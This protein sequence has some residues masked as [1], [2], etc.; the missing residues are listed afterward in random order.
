MAIWDGFEIGR[1]RYRLRLAGEVRFHF[2][3]EGVL[4][5]VLS[6]ALGRHELPAG[7]MAA[8]PES[9]RV[10]YGAGDPYVFGVTLAGEAAGLLDELTG[11]L[12]RLGEAPPE[13]RPAP[14]LGGNFRLET[15]EELGPPDLAGELAALDGADAV[16]LQLLSPFRLE[17]PDDA[18]RRGAGFLDAGCFPPEH[19]LD[20]LWSRLFHLV[21]GRW[22][23]AADRAADRPPLP[24]EL[25]AD[26]AG[27]VWL[28]VPV[29]GKKERK[30]PY[31]LGG[32]VGTVGLSGLPAAWLPWL[33]LG[34]HLHAGAS[35]GYGLGRYRIT[36]TALAF[37]EPFLPATSALARAARREALDAA[38]D[39]V[40]ARSEAAGEDGL[41]P[42]RFAEQA[43]RRLGRLAGDLLHG[44]YR[45]AP[46][47][48]LLLLKDDGGLRP[49]AV[50]TV[51]DRVAQR[52]VGQA[53]DPAVETL[54]EDSSYAYRKGLSR[55]GAARA[56]EQAYRD[57]YRYVLDA[58][59]ESFFD[60]VPWPPLLAK[61]RALFP[62]EPAVD[63]LEEWVRAPV[64]FDGRTIPR[65]RG[66]PQGSS[67]APLLA[68]LYLDQLDE[69]LESQGYRLVRY[70]DDFVVLAKDLDEAKRAHEASRRALADLGLELNDEKTEIR[71][72]DAGFSYL[73]YLFV[74]SL[75]LEQ[76]AEDRRGA[77]RLSAE[78]LDPADVPAA[79]WLARVPFARVRELVAER[80][81]G[82]GSGPRPVRAVPLAEPGPPR[83]PA[84]RPLY[85]SSADVRLRLSGG[86]LAYQG[87]G[88]GAGK[89]PLGDISHLVLCGRVRATLPLLVSLARA[90]VP[91]YL[92]RPSGELEATFAAHDP[93]WPLWA[94]QAERAADDAA[95]LAFARE[96]IAAKLHNQAMLA[97]RFGWGRAAGTSDEIRA[98]ERRTANPETLDA[99]LGLEGRGSAVYFR[100]LA[101]ALPDEWAFSGRAKNPPP[102]PV[103]ALLSFGY[104]LLHNHLATA[105]TLAG[106]HPRIGLLHRRRGAHAALASDLQEE[107]RWLVDA[108]V[109]SLL[110]H[111][112]LTPADFAPSPDGRYPCLLRPDP[113]ARFLE[114]FESRLH[115]ELTPP[116]ETEPTTYRAL[117]TRQARRLADLVRDPAAGYRPF[118]LHA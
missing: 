118:R 65:D 79:S 42:E 45:P 111:R 16:D 68:N 8:A 19:F 35:T 22:P 109:W 117:L 26:P 78:T 7:V 9:G 20:R 69:Q 55:A 108:L 75:V 1:V 64:V 102:D 80:H 70:A 13:D 93:D 37:P 25:A 4:R 110:A 15:V 73:G 17:R 98:L 53:L 71:S 50:P 85:V 90:G 40:V 47:L 23:T 113:R 86:T 97:G 51:R 104:T 48:G 44:R 115:T 39:H 54:L 46:L 76:R 82:G 52:A 32:V 101:E 30:R 112:R 49:L 72:I 103:N 81:A 91:T 58:D 105:L 67:V 14:T 34:R 31:T 59:V 3:H 60:A 56:V 36:D 21:R 12:G 84:A 88:A 77:P 62:F 43:D 5:G 27:L 95:R 61:L 83:P 74:R 87:N 92:C 11:G 94:I 28:D 6:R 57:G 29:Q 100:A 41:T 89:L 38:L 18:K 114:A 66:L 106:L 96:A 33:V 99:L 116:D 24:A 2:R 10:R 63:L 107:M